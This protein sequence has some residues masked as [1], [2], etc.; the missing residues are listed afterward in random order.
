MNLWQR[1]C[2][3][4]FPQIVETVRLTETVVARRGKGGL[5]YESEFNVYVPNL[6]GK[7]WIFSIP[8]KTY[9]AYKAK[10]RSLNNNNENYC[11][12]VTPKETS[13]FDLT[14]KIA[15]GYLGPRWRDRK[16]DLAEL[17]VDFVHQIPYQDREVDYVKYPVE[18]LCEYGGNCIDLSVL[19]A[20]MLEISGIESCFIGTEDHLFLGVDVKSNGHYI[21]HNGKKYYTIEMTGTDL[22]SEPSTEKIGEKDDFD[23]NKIS[24]LTRK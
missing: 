19:G 11:R 9:I 15:E 5:K 17:I 16:I 6:R 3:H 22:P 18:T 23:R 10:P 20:T 12:Y 4:L 14:T 8:T 2:K 21:E 24:I 13:I 1:L 7:E